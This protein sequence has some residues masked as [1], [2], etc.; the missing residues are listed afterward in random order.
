MPGR[1]A[2]TAS[3][4]V[5]FLL[6]ERDVPGPLLE[7]SPGMSVL[8]GLNGAGKSRILDDVRSFFHG[9]TSDVVALIRLSSATSAIDWNHETESGDWF[10]NWAR[11]ADVTSAESD[12]RAILARWAGGQSVGR[13]RDSAWRSRLEFGPP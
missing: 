4:L 7:V 9:V 5:G 12:H 1:D 10:P 11:R 2:S 13:R 8:Y 3:A 6:R